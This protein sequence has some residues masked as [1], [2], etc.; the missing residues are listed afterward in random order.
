MRAGEGVRGPCSEDSSPA[1]YDRVGT[2]ALSWDLPHRSLPR[3][4]VFRAQ[5]PNFCPAEG[6]LEAS[7]ESEGSQWA[8]IPSLLAMFPLPTPKPKDA[9]PFA[10]A[11]WTLEG[12]AILSFSLLGS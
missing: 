9:R 1:S 5:D 4:S 3:P 7:P 11:E 6:T 2:S 10:P 12:P 8:S